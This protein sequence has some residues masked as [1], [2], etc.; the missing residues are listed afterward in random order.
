M[1]KLA[2]AY[3]AADEVARNAAKNFYPCFR[4]LPQPQRDATVALYAFLRAIDDVA[5]GD[6]PT[7]EKRRRLA[8]WKS[9][10]DR[11]PK[12]EMFSFERWGPAFADVVR[13][14]ELP[15][16]IIHDAID[17]VAWDLDHSSCRSFAELYGYCYGVASTA[18]LLS[19]RLW[20][21][22]DPR[23]DLPA[24]WLGIAFQLT[25]ILRDVAEDYRHGRCYL[26]ADDLVRFGVSSSNLGGPSSR[27]LCNLIVFEAARARDYF[28]R[29]RDVAQ[30]LPGPGRAVIS[31][32][33]GVYGNLLERI[34]AN[35]AA[36]FSG[37]VS[38][39]KATKLWAILR[40]LPLR[41]L[42]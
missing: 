8:E 28:E 27:G 37:R 30:Y 36:V 22:T 19:I 24:E 42:S 6:L 35:P 11:V 17:G 10:V 1:T 29:G 4:I 16:R 31:A 39:P 12:G 20:G 5:D 3:A 38:T 15:A 32:L 2:E 34:A 23:A 26:P 25:N 33:V 41:F 40:A 14:F 9:A 13:R 21:A 7:E 18:G